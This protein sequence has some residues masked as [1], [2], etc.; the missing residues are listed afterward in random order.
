MQNASTSPA[1]TAGPWFVDRQSPYSAICIKPIPGKI[2]CDI[3]G[4]DAEAE[5]NASLIAAAPELLEYCKMLLEDVERMAEDFE[6]GR[7]WDWSLTEQNLK[8]VIAKAEG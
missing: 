7:E 5:A 1:H 3:E 8:A 2:V 6:I 4:A